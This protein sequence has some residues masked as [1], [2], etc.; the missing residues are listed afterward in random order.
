MVIAQK[1]AVSMHGHKLVEKIL[2]DDLAELIDYLKREGLVS[3]PMTLSNKD[4][5]FTA[6]VYEKPK[7]QEQE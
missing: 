6:E 7:E 2:C 5:V 1:N 3:H 4:N